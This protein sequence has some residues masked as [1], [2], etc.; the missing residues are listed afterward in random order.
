[1]IDP[2]PEEW[3]VSDINFEIRGRAAVIGIA[4]CLLLFWPGASG[5]QGVKPTDRAEALRLCREH[6]EVEAF[7]LLEKLFKA[8]PDDREIKERYA[9]TLAGI[10]TLASEEEQTKGVLLA[11]KLLLELKEAGP[12]SDLGE[13]LLAMIPP[14]GKYSP[15]STNKAALAAMKAGEAAF[16]KRDFPKARAS[17]ELALTL[18]PKLYAAALFAGDSW[19]AQGKM[20]EA[21]PWFAK[22]AKID[23]N[24]T[25]AFRY[26]GDALVKQGKMKEA[27][28]KFFMAIVAEPYYR[29][30]WLS[31][32]QWAKVNGVELTHPRI[33]PP[34]PKPGEARA[35]SIEDG[36]TSLAVYDAI[37][38]AWKDALFKVKHPKEP[39]YRHTL[40]EE[41]AALRAT[42]ADIAKDTAAGKIKELDATLANLVK[43]DKE[44]LIEV[45][46]LLARPDDGI[47]KDYPAYRDKH[48]DKVIDYLSRYVAPL[49]DKSK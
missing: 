17:Y 3:P 29:P 19:F 33:M 6:R 15:T 36:T 41:S 10:S 47:A 4:S 23:P 48:R 32:G 28:D 16:A 49:P 5:A 40:E 7:P 9:C 37:R 30:G 35:V 26:W 14:D 8:D 25:G 45:Y 11:R 22:A 38:D 2:P 21:I 39:A 44:G 24:Q 34:D 12:L 20:D 18:D 43:L 46:V 42:I 27:R 13:S 1:M 31:L